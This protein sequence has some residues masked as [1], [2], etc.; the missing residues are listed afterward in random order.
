[1][2]FRMLDTTDRIE[3]ENLWDYCFEKRD[4]PF[5]KWFF[6]EYFQYDRTIGG[7]TG[8]GLQTMLNL[9][10][11]EL[12]LKGQKLQTSYIIGVTT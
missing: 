1:M 3:I 6:A 7:F 5:F 12:I 2:D 4:N 8:D 9:A 10:P 11:Y